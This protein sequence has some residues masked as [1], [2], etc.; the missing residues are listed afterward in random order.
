MVVPVAWVA[1]RMMATAEAENFIGKIVVKD[2]GSCLNE[3][4]IVT[5]NDWKDGD[6]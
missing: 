4:M 6:K 2:V 3:M 5:R 1:P